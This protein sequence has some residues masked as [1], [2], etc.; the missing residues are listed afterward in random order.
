MTF[1]QTV[2]GE[3]TTQS[4]KEI[5]QNCLNKV[6]EVHTYDENGLRIH[7]DNWKGEIRKNGTM[8]YTQRIR[9][10][11]A[12]SEPSWWGTDR[13]GILRLQNVNHWIETIYFWRERGM[14]AY[15]AEWTKNEKGVSISFLF[16]SIYGSI[17]KGYEEW[18]E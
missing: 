4:L 16:P 2:M 14:F 12:S 15:Q 10:K 9:C 1:R 13:T 7:P 3:N 6:W 17:S 18:L 11:S 5:I 8:I